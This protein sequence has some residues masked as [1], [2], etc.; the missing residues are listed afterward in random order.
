MTRNSVTVPRISIGAALAVNP[1]DESWLVAY[2]NNPDLTGEQAARGPDGVGFLDRNFGSNSPAPAIT[3][4]NYSI[5]GTRNL[6]VTP[7]LYRFS[8]TGND[9]VRLYIDD[10]LQVNEWTMDSIQCY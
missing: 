7:G 1:P 6:T 2:F 10:V 4:A 8:L 5:R 9:D 3:T